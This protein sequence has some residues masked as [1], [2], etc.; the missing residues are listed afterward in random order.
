MILFQV[1]QNSSVCYHTVF[2]L[3]PPSE[4]Y[5]QNGSAEFHETW[6]VCRYE[7]SKI[8]HDFSFTQKLWENSD[9][10]SSL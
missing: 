8:Y 6:W 3:L 1:S 9:Q 7:Y 4:A 2:P 5:L 10:K